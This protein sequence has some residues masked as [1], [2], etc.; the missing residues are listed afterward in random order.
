MLCE[1][2]SVDSCFNCSNKL[3]NICVMGASIS[4]LL[5]VELL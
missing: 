5:L 4:V 2:V 3:L 1:F